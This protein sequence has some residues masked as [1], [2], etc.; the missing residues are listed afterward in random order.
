MLMGTFI[1]QGC[2]NAEPGEHGGDLNQKDE[3]AILRAFRFKHGV[4]ADLHSR[5]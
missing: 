4:I 5:E 1:K 3:F 2:E